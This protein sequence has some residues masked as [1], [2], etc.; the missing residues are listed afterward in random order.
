MGGRGVSKRLFLISELEGGL[1]NDYLIK[2]KK[3]IIIFYAFLKKIVDFL[4]KSHKNE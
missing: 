3:Y 2:N 1:S 4:I